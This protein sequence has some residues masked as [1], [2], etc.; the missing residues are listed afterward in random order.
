MYRVRF[1]LM[2]LACWAS[3][4]RGLLEDYELSFRAIPFLDT[5]V[6]RTFTHAYAAFSGL[7]RWHYVF[8]SE[9]GAVAIKRRWF[10]VTRAETFTFVRSIKAFEKIRLRTRLVSW[11]DECFFLEQNFFVGAEIRAVAY[12]EGVVRAPEGHLKPVEAFKIF[13][14]HIEAPPMPADIAAWH[15]VQKAIRLPYG[16]P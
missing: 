10:P 4:K 8:S 12:T 6:T 13:G 1:L 14:R 11:N 9:V 15:S 7:G 16:K 5:D 3:K 2:M